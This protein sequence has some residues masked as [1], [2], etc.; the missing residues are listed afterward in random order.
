MV[1]K[2]PHFD[3]VWGPSEQPDQLRIDKRPLRF[4][5]INEYLVNGVTAAA[6]A[7]LIALRTVFAADLRRPPPAPADF[8]GV[9]VSPLPGRDADVAALV[10]ELGCRRLL[11]R[12]PVWW[13]ERLSELR[14][15]VDRFTGCDVLV[16]IV[17]DRRSVCEPHQW[18]A[19][20]AAIFTAFAGRVSHFQ[21]PMSPNRT[22][23]GCI[24]LGEALDL[25]DAAEEV[26]ARFPWVKLVGPGIIDFEPMAWFRGLINLRRY[27][28]DAVGALLYVDRRGSPAGKQLGGFDLGA[29]LRL[30][31]AM[32]ALSPRCP[33]RAATPLWITEMNWPLAGTGTWSPTSGNEQVSEEQAATY[34]R[35]YYQVAHASGLVERVYW[36]QLVH[37][38]Y[39]LID[40]RGGTLR[41]RPA[42]HEL[43]RLVSG[44][45]LTRT[46]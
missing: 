18:R 39:G 42:F 24:H 20:L 27:R 33:Q 32:V 1:S 25:L 30:W 26:R 5:S 14:R 36:W 9:A 46:R 12:V 34:L 17:Q 11:L 2:H 29:K 3:Q 35:E 23:W 22:K 8:A 43:R 31:K 45:T 19:D 7:P 4:A 38:G 37:P 10:A 28:L 16:A 44:E 40:S 15:F 21:L 41:R 13:R 6:W